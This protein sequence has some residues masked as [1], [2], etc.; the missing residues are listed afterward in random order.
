MSLQNIRMSSLADKHAKAEEEA[1]KPKKVVKKVVKDKV[2][3][4]KVVKK[5]K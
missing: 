4:K 3:K 2:V 5:K 1:N